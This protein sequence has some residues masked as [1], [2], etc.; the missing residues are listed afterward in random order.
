[1]PASRPSWPRELLWVLGTALV[2]TLVT[3]I[4]LKLWDASPTV[5]ISGAFNDATFFLSAVKGVVEHGWFWHNPDLAAPFGQTNFDFAA[6]FGDS[7]H[8]LIVSAL[9]LVISNPVVVFNGFYLLCFPLTA[10]TAYL[11]LRDLGSE[12]V[13]ALVMGVLFAF[14]PYHLLRHQNHLFLAAYYAVPLGVWLVVALSEGRTLIGRADRRR[15]AL[16]LF[17]CAVVAS[18]SNYYAVFAMLAIL[19]VVPVAALARRS[20]R[21]ALQGLFV[22]VAIAIVFGI[23]HAPPVIYAHEHGR[24]TAI[25][26]RGPAES[27]DFG[28]K[29]TQ[30]V[31]PRPD[32]RIEALARRARAY[33]ARTPITAEG[34]S[35]SLGVV[36]TLGLLCALLVLLTTGLGDRDVSLRRQRVSIAG[37]VALVCFLIGTISG[38]SALIAFE[39]TPQVR[40]W[41]RISLLIAF[42]ALIAAALALTALGDRLRARGRGPWILGVLVAVIGVLGVLDQTSAHD[43]PAYAAIKAGWNNDDAFVHAMEQR[44]PH[45]TRVLQLPY[46]PYPENGP[47]NGMLDYD[48]FKG[49]I[50]SRHLRW[51]YGSTKGRPADWQ[52]D[53]QALAPDDLAIAAT[54][55]GFR[56]MYVD[57]AGYADHGAAVDAALTKLSGA[58]PAGVSADGRLDWYDLRPLAARVAK[59]TTPGERVIVSD[60]LLKPVDLAFG[61]GFSFPQVDAGGPFRWA[62]TDAQLALD[63]PLD[64]PRKVRLTATVFGG[65]A[66]PST[67]TLT[68]PGGRRRILKAAAAGAA[69][70]VQFVVAPGRSAIAVHTDGPAAPNDPNDIR[71]KRLRVSNPLLREDLLQ[72]DVLAKIAR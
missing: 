17:V 46:T 1:M 40:G 18:A 64:T 3:V 20:G 31:L 38:I 62:A 4:D 15:T 39:I 70:T 61:A 66:Q 13:V 42:A 35:P 8:Y 11:V 67:V 28:L 68:L 10:V 52:A 72:T 12:R 56:A 45:G 49:Y 63:N 65:A 21:I 26:E 6:D 71:D 59:N 55:A 24:N 57:R 5:P 7:G 29:L 41:N 23:C 32:H 27:E 14:L 60:A 22:L 51:S 33:E 54:T 69:L 48:L 58:G 53:V 50:H 9:G 47:V 19:F 36:A 34:F 44:L 16:T 2:A 37:A 25:A 30:M 43:V